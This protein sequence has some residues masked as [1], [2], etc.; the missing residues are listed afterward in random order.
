MIRANQR[1]CR[2]RCT[3]NVQKVSAEM[4]FPAILSR[5]SPYNRRRR[6]DRMDRRRT[7]ARSSTRLA[8]SSLSLSDRRKR[9]FPAGRSFGC[10]GAIKNSPVSGAWIADGTK[11]ATSRS[12]SRRSPHVSLSRSF[13]YLFLA[14]SVYRRDS[15]DW[16][17]YQQVCRS[18]SCPA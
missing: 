17:L 3:G 2:H 13:L 8:G 18:S 1:A 12:S 5:R 11:T 10:G 9:K 7:F 4:T 14:F 15:S 16:Y 6:I